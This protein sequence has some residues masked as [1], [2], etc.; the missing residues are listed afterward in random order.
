MFVLGAGVSGKLTGM[1][2][3]DRTAFVGVVHKRGEMLGRICS[4]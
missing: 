1:G 3:Q 2:G 4:T